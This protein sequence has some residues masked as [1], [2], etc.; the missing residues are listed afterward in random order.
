MNTPEALD[1]SNVVD[2]N[3]L[4]K[5]EIETIN[6]LIESLDGEMLTLVVKR[7]RMVVL[8]DALLGALPESAASDE[9]PV[10]ASCEPQS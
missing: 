10:P 9:F 7:A 6:T 2:R 4:L 5:G 8:R 1:T 3:S